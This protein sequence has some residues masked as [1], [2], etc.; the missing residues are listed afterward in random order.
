MPHSIPYS[1]DGSKG[2]LRTRKD[3][4]LTVYILTAAVIALLLSLADRI[5]EN[6]PPDHPVVYRESALIG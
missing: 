4:N 6:L 2:R 5:W 3:L 1:G